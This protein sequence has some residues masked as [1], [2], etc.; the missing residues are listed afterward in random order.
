MVTKRKSKSPATR[1]EHDSLGAVEVP[2]DKLWGAQTQRALQHFRI[3]NELMPGELIPAY[4]LV[5][6]AVALVNHGTGHLPRRQKILIVRVCDEI[7][8]GQH[9]DQFPLPVWISGSG[10]QFNMN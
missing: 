1:I 7:L 10:T 3:G 8:D 2:A 5:K 4:A 9:R 6:K